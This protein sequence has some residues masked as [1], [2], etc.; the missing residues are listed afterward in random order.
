MLWSVLGIHVFPFRSFSSP[1]QDLIGTLT[2]V[3]FF[4]YETS[5]GYVK[6]P[7]DPQKLFSLFQEPIKCKTPRNP[8]NGHSFGETYTVGAEVTFSCEEGYQLVGAARITC[9]ESGEWS[10]LIPYCEGMLSKFP[11]AY[12]VQQC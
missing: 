6:D 4:C 5:C 9:L 1:L 8:E 2:A 7:V 10:H 11:R 3:E 12:G